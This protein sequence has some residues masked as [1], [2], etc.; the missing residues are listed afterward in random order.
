M[1][2]KI[3]TF[4]SWSAA[5]TSVRWRVWA[6]GVEASRSSRALRAMMSWRS[7]GVRY[8]AEEGESA[9]KNQPKTPRQMEGRPSMMRSLGGIHELGKPSWQ[10]V[11]RV[12][13]HHLQARKLRIPS[14]YPI[15]Y[16]SKPPTAPA[17]AAPLKR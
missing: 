3:Q 11:S 6:E 2:Q 8:Q 12:K 16:A 13:T 14:I 17:T 4:Q 1:R 7:E 9:R 10:P 5:T 15:A